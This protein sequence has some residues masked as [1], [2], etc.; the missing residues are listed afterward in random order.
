MTCGY[1]FGQPIACDRP[2]RGLVPIPEATA[3]V[4]SIAV[5]WRAPRSGNSASPD[6]PIWA[7]V[8]DAL[9]FSPPGVGHYRC[10]AR[11]ITVTP[12]PRAD[13]DAVEALLIATA[14]PAVMWLQ[15]QFM[16]HAA[17]IVPARGNRALAIVGAS[18]SGKSWLAAAFLARG[19][20]LLA[21]DSLAMRCTGDDAVGS[22]L[23]GGYHLAD[24]EAEQRRFHGVP[25]TDACVSA[26]IG[27]IVILADDA[28]LGGGRL[29]GVEALA[30]L[31]RHRHRVSVP[32]AIGGEPKTLIDAAQV[33]RSTP[34]FTWRSAEGDALL[35]QG[36][37]MTRDARGSG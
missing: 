37:G 18:G 5:T 12:I 17:A 22:G 16:L 27:A 32:R 24:A 14:L 34:V 36:V 9:D 29:V 4:P 13:P 8:G 35:D 33:A 28:P 30:A 15:G 7:R 26:R 1:G 23:A 6:V 3:A 25:A 19:A 31:L 20:R 2:I 21:D 11:T 10:T